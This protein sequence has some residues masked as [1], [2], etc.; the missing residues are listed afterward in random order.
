MVRRKMMNSV[1]RT[2]YEDF[3]DD[4]LTEYPETETEDSEFN[5]TSTNVNHGNGLFSKSGQSL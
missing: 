4:E 2:V 1:R 3:G 5:S